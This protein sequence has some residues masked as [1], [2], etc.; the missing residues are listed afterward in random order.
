M[1]VCYFHNAGQP[2]DGEKNI[3][4]LNNYALL[5]CMG[6]VGVTLRSIFLANHRLRASRVLH[7]DLLDKVMACPVAFFDSTP[8]GR[9]LNR[10]SSDLQTIDEELSSNISQLFNAGFN[11][12]AAVGGIAGATKGTFLL[13]LFPLSLVY[14]QAQIFFRKSSTEIQRLE[15]ISKSPIYANFSQ[16]LAGISTIR[17][18]GDQG[19]FIS[20]FEK[21]ADKNSVAQILLQL[22]FQWLS[23]RLDF[24]G[25][26]TSF[27]VAALAI[28]FPG[29]VPAGF[30]AIGLSFSFDMCGYLKYAV[31]MVAQVEANMNAVERIQYYADELPRE[32][33][34][35]AVVEDFKDKNDHDD[36]KVPA[37]SS[38]PD[39][40]PHTGEI[41][42]K[43]VRMAYGEGQ[44]VLK[45]LNM[46]IKNKEKIGIAG[47]TGS[48]KS[49]LMVALFRIENFRGSIHI[50]GIDT[51]CIPLE[52][53]RSK[54][55]IIPQDPVMFAASV[56]FNLDPCNNHTDEEIWDVLA[57]VDMKKTIDSLPQKLDDMVSEG[58]D[59]FSAG[60]R[61]LICIGRA[62]LR[63]PSIL[64]LDEATASIDNDTDDLVQTMIRSSFKNSTVLTIAH[65]LHTII[66]ADRIV[67][68]DNG[69]VAE[70]DSPDL[71]L[72]KPDGIFRK[73]WDK[74]QSSHGGQVAM[75][76]KDSIEK[77]LNKDESS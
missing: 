26:I 70:I 2:F 75:R 5:A 60:Q 28:S 71:L 29:F 40:W 20:Q 19:A 15:S 65:R 55:G 64:V 42:M 50:D 4:Y 3:S 33:S 62:L 21:N 31:R 35:I 7:N 49:S 54:I 48:G 37:V 45:G 69:V 44:D 36:P 8:I 52:I 14:Y 13:I 56:R 53:L 72:E 59:N 66:D 63:N 46:S 61:Q 77:G 25:A 18:Y 32:L 74:N 9:V 58:G 67:V 47:R 73:L 57:K 10:F 24:I 41:V 11:V 27:F 34:V 1:Y 30:V 39:N 23:L 6:I 16:T 38:I 51:K 12:L 22:A 68:M 76:K 17:A 43:D